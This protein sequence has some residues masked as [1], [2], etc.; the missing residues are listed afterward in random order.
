[1]REGLR[2]AGFEVEKA[3]GFGGKR[4]MLRGRWVGRA[5]SPD[6]AAPTPVRV[7]RLGGVTREKASPF[8]LLQSE[9]SLVWPELMAQLDADAKA[10][11]VKTLLLKVGG[12]ELGAA[13]AEELAAAIER[14]RA[15]KK[16]VVV[17]VERPNLLTLVASGPADLVAMTPESL[18]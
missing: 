15:A 18:T 9:G 14:V 4:Q 2:R 7:Y 10:P 11:A 1:M 8:E 16:R 12:I 6:A 13:Q 17:Y 3:P 5:S